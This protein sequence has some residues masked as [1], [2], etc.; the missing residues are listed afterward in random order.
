MSFYRRANIPGSTVFLTIVTHQRKPLFLDPENIRKLKQACVVVMKERPFSIDAAVILPEHVHFLWSLPPGDSDYS[1]R[2][3]R[4]K[5]LFTKALRGSN[6]LPTNVSM[7]RR[8]HRESDVWQ[9]RFY[10]HTISGEVDLCQHLNYLHFNPVKHGLVKCVHQWQYSSF[11]RAVKRGKYQNDWGCQCDG[12]NLSPD[13][14]DLMNLD[15]GE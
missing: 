4:M 7:S 15:L 8:K 13:I 12:V 11:H 5:V 10:E 9:R 3:G 6:A 14:V 1:Y 2:V